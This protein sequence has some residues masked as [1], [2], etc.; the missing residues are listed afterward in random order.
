MSNWDR[1]CRSCR[2]SPSVPER[3]AADGGRG[4]QWRIRQRQSLDHR[5]AGRDRDLHGGARHH[6]RQRRAALHLRRTCRLQRRSLLGHHHLSRRQFDRAV[7]QRLDRAD[8]RPQEFLSGLHRAVHGEFAVVRLCVEF[9][10]AAGVPRHAGAG[11]RRHDAGGAIDPGGGLPAREAQPGLCALRHRGRGGARG[12]ADARRLAQR[13]SVLALVLPDQRAG[14][15]DLA[16]ADL[17]DH[18]EFAGE[19]EGART[20]L[21][22]GARTSTSSASCWSRRSSAGSKSCSTAARSTTG[23]ARPSS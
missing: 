19:A 8:V 16:G 22:Q 11:R 7:R 13:Q 5:G 1:A 17:S 10:G 2:P 18:S 4:S 14:R 20:A 12:R 23:S 9:A 6:D 21:G 15:T 3:T